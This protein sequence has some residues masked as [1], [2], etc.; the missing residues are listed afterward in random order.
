MRYLHPDR[1]G[2]GGTEEVRLRHRVEC[3]TGKSRSLSLQS[4]KAAQ[5]MKVQTRQPKGEQGAGRSSLTD[6]RL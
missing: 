3:F 5:G 1:F 6:E 2:L 4:T